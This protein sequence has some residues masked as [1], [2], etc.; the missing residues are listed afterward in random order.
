M[1]SCVPFEIF[2]NLIIGICVGLSSFLI[3]DVIQK[4][5]SGESYQA[6]QSQFNE[7][8]LPPVLTICPGPG[9]KVLGPFMNKEQLLSSSYSAEELFHPKTLT[10]LRN[11]SLYNFKQQYSSYRGLCYV[12]QKLTAEGISEF[13]FEIVIND[14]IDYNCMLHEPDENEWLFMNVYPYDLHTTNINANNSDNVGAAGI[15]FYQVFL[16]YRPR[17]L[18]LHYLWW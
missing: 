1:L 15:Y 9:Y 12:I 18:N 16:K 14:Q 5:L 4:N 11:T 13:S 3:H 7:K 8:L 6:V 10:R 2:K 17:N